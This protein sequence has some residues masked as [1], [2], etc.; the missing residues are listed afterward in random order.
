MSL[1]EIGKW[2]NRLEYQVKVGVE[3]SKRFTELKRKLEKGYGINL[4]DFLGEIVDAYEKG[5][6]DCREY[7]QLYEYS[8]D[9]N[10]K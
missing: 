10:K 2:A 6:I 1:K 5:E 3:M 9:K 4:Y 7:I 8:T